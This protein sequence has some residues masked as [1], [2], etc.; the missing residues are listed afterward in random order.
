MSARRYWGGP[1]MRL[2]LVGLIMSLATGATLA[3]SIGDVARGKGLAMS[4]C[5]DCHNVVASP[6][7]SPNE[8]A[9]PFEA[10]ANMPGVSEMA[11]MVFFQ[12]PHEAMPNL[13]I[14]PTERDDLVAYIMSL[15]R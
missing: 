4:I 3:Q 12:M 5:S 10:V 11:L 7:G 6:D 15:K 1:V 2:L 9:P 14:M 13:I 8:Q